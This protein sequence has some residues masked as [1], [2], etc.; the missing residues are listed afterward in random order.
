SSKYSGR[1]TMSRLPPREKEMILSR[2][3][4]RRS[5]YIQIE[6]SIQEKR[7][8]KQME[9]K[10]LE[11]AAQQRTATLQQRIDALLEE[12]QRLNDTLSEEIQKVKETLAE[13]MS[14]VAAK[15]NTII[16]ELDNQLQGLQ[17]LTSSAETGIKV[18]IRDR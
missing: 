5:K 7:Q 11:D 12:T 3:E 16:Q 4:E 8:Q 15:Y 1:S 2:K 17:R 10:E 14:K 6:N 9:A 13:D 18:L